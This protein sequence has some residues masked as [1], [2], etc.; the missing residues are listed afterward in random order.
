MLFDRLTFGYRRG[1]TVL[2]NF[3]WEVEPGRTVLLGPNGAG[4][5][6]LLAIGADAE[7]PWDGTVV[8]DGLAPGRW[9]PSR[10]RYRRLVGWM[11]QHV[12]TVPGMTGREQVA[13]AG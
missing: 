5:S 6:T 1:R 10:A 2:Q 11:P 7:R 4:K 8:I 12:R 13:Y 3:T 9:H